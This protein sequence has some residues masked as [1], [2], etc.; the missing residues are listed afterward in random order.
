[1][2][3]TFPRAHTHPRSRCQQRATTRRVW[4]N[5]SNYADISV[6]VGHGAIALSV[7]RDAAREMKADGF[8]SDEIDR[9]CRRALVEIDG[10]PMTVI[11]GRRRRSRHYFRNRQQGLACRRFRH[12]R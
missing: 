4:D 10:Q 8:G 7:S 2:T 3:D 5:H 12:R 11:A 9:V 6:P 1:M